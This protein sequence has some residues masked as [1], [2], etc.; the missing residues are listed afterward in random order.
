MPEIN[1][2]RLVARTPLAIVGKLELI[3]ISTYQ[4]T[5]E[6]QNLTFLLRPDFPRAFGSY[7]FNLNK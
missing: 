7:W 4:N 6:L 2:A 3:A 5:E 1:H